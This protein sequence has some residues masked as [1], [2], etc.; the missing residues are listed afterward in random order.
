MQYEQYATIRVTY[1]ADLGQRRLARQNGPRG[2][3]TVGCRVQGRARGRASL[4]VIQY[5]V[6]EKLSYRRT[7]EQFSEAL[8]LR[9]TSRTK[10]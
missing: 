8:C 3:A 1:G 6:W 10:K 4:Q 9:P 5:T 2:L 7:T